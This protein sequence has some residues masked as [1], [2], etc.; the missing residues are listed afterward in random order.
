VIAHVTPIAVTRPPTPPTRDA[1]RAA[2]TRV[3][4]ARSLS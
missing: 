4:L 1:L 2:P 3:A